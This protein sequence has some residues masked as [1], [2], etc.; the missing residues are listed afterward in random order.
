MEPVV[1]WSLQGGVF[2]LDKEESDL[3][4]KVSSPS[5]ELGRVELITREDRGPVSVDGFLDLS[6]TSLSRSLWDLI[7]FLN[8]PQET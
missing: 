4:D 6:A 7:G 5:I 8:W 3:S 2:I 1:G